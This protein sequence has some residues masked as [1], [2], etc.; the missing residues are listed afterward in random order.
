MPPKPENKNSKYVII[1][2]LIFLVGL[3][4]LSVVGVVFS[5][6]NSS[7]LPPATE[8]PI[9]PTQTGGEDLSAV[10]DILTKGMVASIAFN[11][12]QEM[13]LKETA[14][15]E[16]AI[17]PFISEEKI[18][19][20]IE[21]EG[22]IQTGTVLVTPLTKVTLIAQDGQAF[23]IQKLH[24]SDIQAVDEHEGTTTWQWQV[25]A[26]KGG[27]QTMT[28]VVYRLI[29]FQGQN[30]WRQVETYRADINVEVGLQQRIFAFDWKW[31][32]GLLLTSIIIPL[33]MRSLDQRKLKAGKKRK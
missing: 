3:V 13:N 33:Y 27:Q 7:L 22:Q 6:I 29:Q 28:I 23:D 16:L 10:D 4:A 12:P 14:T 26:K 31:L 24:D 18:A 15:I 5:T 19:Q 1:S 17:D 21:A 8:S 30:Y 32:I 2:I 25:T 20:Q 11:A 9:T